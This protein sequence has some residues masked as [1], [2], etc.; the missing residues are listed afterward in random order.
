MRLII[1][2]LILIYNLNLASGQNF[3]DQKYDRQ[4]IIMDYF[5]SGCT[6]LDPND[7]VIKVGTIFDF[8]NDTLEM[9]VADTINVP[10][11]E[12]KYFTLGNVSQICNEEGE[13]LAYFNGAELWDRFGK[14]QILNI[15]YDEESKEY[16]SVFGDAN[17][18]IL[19]FPGIEKQ[20]ILINANDFNYDPISGVTMAEDFSAVIFNEKNNGSL[21]IFETI[22]KI[23]KGKYCF[24][25]VITACRH[26]NG[27]DWWLVCPR[28][29]SNVFSFFLLDPSGIKFH[30]SQIVSS[31]ILYSS[32]A[33]TFSPDGRWYTRTESKNAGNG[34]RI[35]YGQIFEFDRCSGIFTE[36]YEYT[37]PAEDTT[38]LGQIIF[39]KTSQYFY[40]L[41]AGTIYQGNINKPMTIENLEKVGAFNSEIKDFS[42]FNLIGPG[43]LAPDNKIYSFDGRWSFGT[44][45]INYPSEE[46]Q[47]CGFEYST[48]WKPACGSLGLGNMPDFNLGPVD[49]SS[50]DTLGLDNPLSVDLPKE[51]SDFIVY[52]NPTNGL[53]YGEG[54]IIYKDHFL[55]IFD[56]TGKTLYEGNSEDLRTGIDL[57]D[58]PSGIY[59]IYIHEIGIKKIVKI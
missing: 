53:I 4:R 13:L 56:I 37:F 57:S 47:N 8:R 17:S 7:T 18:V 46:G 16:G 26:A 10:N 35:D 30:H 51:K 42:G 44:S 5:A 36:P 11:Q 2:P 29:R 12:V 22:P 33:P 54:E 9:R 23:H 41:R 45:V 19:P 21:D 24:D 25:G 50:C 40:F 20:Y 38:S 39:D 52:P 6:N 15:F 3:I 27:R 14:K 1:V 32:Y 28:R 55:K 31:N 58:Q 34:K 59:F 49:G 48:L 43:F